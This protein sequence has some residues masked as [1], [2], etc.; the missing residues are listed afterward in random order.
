MLEGVLELTVDGVLRL[1]PAEHSF[2]FLSDRR[3]TYR[4]GGET[5]CRVLWVNTPPT[6]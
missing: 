4:N 6:F 5:L 3:H 1:L 2:F